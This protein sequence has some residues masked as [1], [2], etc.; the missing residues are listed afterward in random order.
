MVFSPPLRLTNRDNDLVN[1]LK[2]HLFWPSSINVYV[3]SSSTFNVQ[4]PSKS[5]KACSQSCLRSWNLIPEQHIYLYISTLY[6][7]INISTRSERVSFYPTFIT[8][9]SCTCVSR[10]SLI[11]Q[12]W[13]SEIYPRSYRSSDSYGADR[14][15]DWSPFS[16]RTFPEYVLVSKSAGGALISLVW[17]DET[18]PT[19][20]SHG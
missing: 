10:P 18:G 5:P 17:R 15:T 14:R 8:F 4:L 7:Y 13:S 12:T 3:H 2:K 11:R 20:L 9:L 16:G 19:F 1:L 6:S